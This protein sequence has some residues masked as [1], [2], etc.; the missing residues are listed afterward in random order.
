MSAP[1]PPWFKPVVIIALLWN[2]IGVIMFFAQLT[3]TEESFNAMESAELAEFYRGY[4]KWP[5]AGTGLAVFAGV[6]GCLGLLRGK[7]WAF[8]AFALSLVGIVVQNIYPFLMSD[9]VAIAGTSAAV[10]PALVAV[11][12]VALL[13]LAAKASKAGWAA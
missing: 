3:L 10:M 8:A 5:L 12:A 9:F 11:I 6:A 7:K 4:P 13:A 1:K 2:L